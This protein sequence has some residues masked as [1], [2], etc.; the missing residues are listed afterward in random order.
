MII[1]QIMARDVGGVADFAEAL[2]KR[3]SEVGHS[4][5][6]L[7][8]RKEPTAD[9]FNVRGDITLLHMSNYEFA[10]RGLCYWLPERWSN[11]TFRARS[12][13]FVVFFHELFASG[14][15]WKSAFWVSPIQKH[16]L[17]KIARQSSVVLTNSSTHKERLKALCP[18]LTDIHHS[19]VFS[20]V[21][22]SENFP[23]T[24]SR[25]G[26][27]IFG[28]EARRRVAV[29]KI[30][31]Q[32]WIES[33]GMPVLEI[34]SGAAVG[35]K[36]WNFQKDLDS[37]QVAERLRRA[38]FGLV[39]HDGR[40]LAK[41][42]VFAAYVAHGCIPIV[43]QPAGSEC[44]GLLSG[45]HYAEPRSIMSLSQDQL[46]SISSNAWSWYKQHNLNSQADYILGNIVTSRLG[47]N[48]EADRV[49]LL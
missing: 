16:I 5:R 13:V 22:E 36:C 17:R 2:S 41:S 34:G 29:E 8:W 3:W 43:S 26:I 37:S 49:G 35:P 38:K 44:D 11:P 14:P 48:K 9:D 39:A 31:G 18:E 25:S 30:G 27:V 4:V 7:R 6:N 10:S 40:D 28:T 1:S 33:I 21:G 20:N 24:Q 12:A 47:V 15:P 42:G 45:C 23:D 32:T 19:P 46:R